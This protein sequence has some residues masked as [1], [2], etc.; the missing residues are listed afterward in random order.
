MVYKDNLK[1]DLRNKTCMNFYCLS[2][3]FYFTMRNE[4]ECKC[5]DIDAKTKNTSDNC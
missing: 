3:Y 2:V 5:K 1:I 4:I